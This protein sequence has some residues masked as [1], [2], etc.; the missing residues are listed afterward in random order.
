L[1]VE[2][3]DALAFENPDGSIV[4]IVFNGDDAPQATTLGV[5]TARLGLDVPARGWATVRW[6]G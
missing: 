1:G 2:G 4:T 5:G 3:G 6:P